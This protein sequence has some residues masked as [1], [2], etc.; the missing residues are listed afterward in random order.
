MAQGSEV[1][2]CSEAFYLV[3]VGAVWPDEYIEFYSR[4]VVAEGEEPDSWG[5]WPDERQVRSTRITAT[6]AA[7]LR[8][9]PEALKFHD[10]TGILGEVKE[11]ENLARTNPG[12]II[13]VTSTEPQIKIEYGKTGGGVR[14][15]REI[16]LFP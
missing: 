11:S 4:E 3:E 13:T 15:T 16:T 10:L 12:K 2:R 5:T 1:G 7:I 6:T 8:L 9:W 14:I